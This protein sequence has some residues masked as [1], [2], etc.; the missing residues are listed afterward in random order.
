MPIQGEPHPTL[1]PNLYTQSVLVSDVT[2][3]ND[4]PDQLSYLGQ[5]F[6]MRQR[7]YNVPLNGG[8]VSF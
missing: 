3:R 6:G 7:P 8:E 2:R 5:S 4:I 1:D